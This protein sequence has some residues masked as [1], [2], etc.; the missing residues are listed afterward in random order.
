LHVVNTSSSSTIVG[1]ESTGRI[2]DLDLKTSDGTVTISNSY[3]SLLFDLASGKTVTFRDNYVENFRIAGDGKVGIGG[4]SSPD[5]VLEITNQSAGTNYFMV[6]SSATGDG[7]I[8]I[9]NSTGNVGIGTPNPATKLNVVDVQQEGSN[10]FNSI[11][12]NGTANHQGTAGGENAIGVYG[13]GKIATATGETEAIGIYGEA[14][15]GNANYAGYFNGNIS[16][17]Q[18]ILFGT[19]GSIC[20]GT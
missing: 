20:T 2:A 1:F 5:A 11:A 17:S 15:G 8:F 14:S 7:N 4:D 3:A 6:S 19:G 18:C 10:N 13:Y 9:V 16:V 12:V